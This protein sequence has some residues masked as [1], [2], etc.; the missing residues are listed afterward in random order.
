[1]PHEF[2]A[3]DAVRLAF[4]WPQDGR[5]QRSDGSKDRLA[6]VFKTDAGGFFASPLSPFPPGA[7]EAAYAIALTGMMKRQLGL[8]PDRDS[9]LKANHVN[10]VQPPNPAIRKW[11]KRGQDSLQYAAAR[12]PDGLLTAMEEKRN[13]AIADKAVNIAQIRRHDPARDRARLRDEDLYSAKRHLPG[14]PARQSGQAARVR[15]AAARHAARTVLSTKPVR[16]ISTGRDL[17]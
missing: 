15:E 14:D 16:A 17:S 9:Y 7:Y 5:M 3:G 11:S 2:T 6:I 1:M 12:V 13:A 10:Y 8:D 4:K